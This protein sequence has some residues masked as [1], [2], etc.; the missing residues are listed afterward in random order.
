V[1]PLR[2][3]LES[4]PEDLPERPVALTFDD[5]YRGHLEVA[6][7]LA[8]RGVSA[9]F[10]VTGAVLDADAEHWWDQ[11]DRLAWAAGD[12]ARRDL[13][14]RLVHAPSAS[15]RSRMLADA[16]SRVASAGDARGVLS[17]PDLRTLAAVPGMDIGAHGAEHLFMPGLSD[18]AV[19]REMDDGR[20]LLEQALERS[21]DLFA[22]PYGGCDDRVSGGARQRFAYSMACDPAVVRTSFDAARVPRLDVKRWSA[23]ELAA[24]LEALFDPPDDR[25]AISFLP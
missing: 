24:R 6:S 8:A 9:T 7:T 2:R 21:V 1:V 10:F 12:A 15:E 18:E 20:R 4:A 13:H 3:L 14:D 5:G 22:F 19:A 25:P 11:L 16:R 17:V 23:R